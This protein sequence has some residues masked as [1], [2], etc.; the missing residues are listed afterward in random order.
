MGVFQAR[1]DPGFNGCSRLVWGN[2]RVAP[3]SFRRPDIRTQAPGFDLVLLVVAGA[4]LPV[5]IA[6]ESIG[7]LF[8]SCGRARKQ[9]HHS[10]QAHSDQEENPSEQP[11]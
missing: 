1:A 5:L 6:S 9:D 2:R 11:P 3:L 8:L 10:Q 4:D 7:Y